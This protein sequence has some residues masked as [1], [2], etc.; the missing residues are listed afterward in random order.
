MCLLI[1]ISPHW[2]KPEEKEREVKK[3][4]TGGGREMEGFVLSKLHCRSLLYYTAKSYV[5]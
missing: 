3:K 5:C 2:S 1:S 4:K